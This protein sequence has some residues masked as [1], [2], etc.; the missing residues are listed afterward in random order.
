MNLKKL[1]RYAPP[2]FPVKNELRIFALSLLP[3]FLFSLSFFVRYANHYADVEAVRKA[4]VFYM[5]NEDRY[6]MP[7]FETLLGTMFGHTFFLFGLTGAVILGIVFY[8]YVS[9]YQ[10]SKS[11]YLMKRLPDKREW[12]IRA[13]A[14]PLVEALATAVLIGVLWLWFYAHYYL[15]TPVE[16]IR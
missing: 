4:S 6:W 7:S 13:L 11:I 8:H 16:W 5:L 1:E 15:N 2:G 3:G 9:Y 10:G 12:H 14:L